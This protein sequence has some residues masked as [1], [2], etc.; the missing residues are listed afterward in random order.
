MLGQATHT[1]THTQ[2]IRARWLYGEKNKIADEK[3]EDD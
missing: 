2:V 3:G 1:H